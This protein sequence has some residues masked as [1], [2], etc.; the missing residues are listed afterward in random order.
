LYTIVLCVFIGVSCLSYLLSKSSGDGKQSI[1]LALIYCLVRTFASFVPFYGSLVL[2]LTPNITLWNVSIQ[3]LVL[4]AA[5]LLLTLIINQIT[6]VLASIYVGNPSLPRQDFL[7]QFAG[8]LF[9]NLAFVDLAPFSFANAATICAV[10]ILSFFITW[11]RDTSVPKERALQHILADFISCLLVLT[12]ISL[13]LFVLGRS[14]WCLLACQMIVPVGEVVKR[15][16]VILV[17]I[18][19]YA[20]I[21][22]VLL[23]K[24]PNLEKTKDCLSKYLFSWVIEAQFVTFFAIV[25]TQ[26]RWWGPV[27]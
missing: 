6:S 13:D 23:R 18:L 1:G 25:F 7:C 3:Y 10:K 16:F 15:T 19:V 20:A 26:Y 11:C 17:V 24:M 4:L 12:V 8:M 27:H 21:G 2:R 9:V 14:K 22:W 5:V